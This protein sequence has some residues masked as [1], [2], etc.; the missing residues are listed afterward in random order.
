MYAIVEIAGKQFKV[1]ENRYIHTP[2]VEGKKNDK[3]T[4]DKVMLIDSGD[5]KV[6]IGTPTISGS[7]IEGKVLD[8]LK[9]KE[10]LVFKK[11]RRKAYQKLTKHRQEY[12]K[13]LIEKISKK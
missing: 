13:I 12:S 3:I 1:I 2:K 4:F 9:D 5:G 6:E 11:K 8:T 7:H 10:I